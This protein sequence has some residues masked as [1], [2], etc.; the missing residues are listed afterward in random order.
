MNVYLTIFTGVIRWVNIAFSLW[1]NG[2]HF[3]WIKH[4]I[5]LFVLDISSSSI[6]SEALVTFVNLIVESS[7]R[8]QAKQTFLLWPKWLVNQ[9]NSASLMSSSCKTVDRYFL[10]RVGVIRWGF[11]RFSIFFVI[12]WRV[13]H[14]F[15]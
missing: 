9:V 3:P 14:S 7:L 2:W 10:V 6:A 1:R 5:N 11:S 8:Y 12:D 13:S 15:R 4:V